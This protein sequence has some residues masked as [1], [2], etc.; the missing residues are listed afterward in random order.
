MKSFY[1][2]IG[3]SLIE[4]LV[5]LMLVSLAAVNISGLQQMVSLQSKNNLSHTSVL[6]LVSKK[7]EE[8]MQYENIQ[9]VTALDGRT[10]TFTERGTTFNLSWNIATDPSVADSAFIRDITITVTWLGSMGQRQTFNYS[11]K[12][13]FSMLLTSGS[14]KKEAF[15]YSIANLLGTNKVNYFESRMHYKEDAYVIYDSKLLQVTDIYFIELQ[16]VGNLNPPIDSAGNVSPGW[17]LLGRIDNED[18]ALL[19]ID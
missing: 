19:F 14:E 9:D 8:V 18:L 2:I 5:A 13:S 17:T 16:E 15:S 3:F 12:I 6:E 7:F 11:R 1:S 4:I 10:S